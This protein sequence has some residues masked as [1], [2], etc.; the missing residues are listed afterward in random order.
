MTSPFELLN[1]WLAEEH[2]AGAPNPCQAVLATCGEEGPHARVVVIREI[3]ERGLLFFTQKGTRKVH[4]IKQNP[5]AALTFWFELLQ[6]QVAIEGI[7]SPLSQSENQQYW[8]SYPRQ[9]Q[10]RFYSYALTSTQPISS[11]EVLEKRKKQIEKKYEG[12]SVPLSAHYCGFL[13]KPSRILF[14]AYRIDELSDVF[15]FRRQGENWI[16]QWLS[17]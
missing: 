14:Y 17:P 8:E 3:N 2:Q 10:L 6:R 1:A 9:A 15:D 16:K 12:T 7:V 11:K 4:E 5:I 13:F